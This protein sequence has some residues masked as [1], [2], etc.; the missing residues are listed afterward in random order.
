MANCANCGDPVIANNGNGYKSDK[1]PNEVFCSPECLNDYSSKKSV[2]FSNIKN[3]AGDIW[4]KENLKESAKF[5][6]GNLWRETLVGEVVSGAGKV[7]SGAGKVVS[8]VGDALKEDSIAIKQLIEKQKEKQEKLCNTSFGDD[9]IEIVDILNNLSLEIRST[10]KNESLIGEEDQ[11][12]L[13]NQY[14]QKYEQGLQR[15][16]LL[17]ADNNTAMISYEEAKAE[18]DKIQ[19]EITKEQAKQKKRERREWIVFG[20]LFVVGIVLF[21][22]LK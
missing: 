7:V 11:E 19:K 21:S 12:N 5:V 6:V 18:F 9:P 13:I 20:I 8:D 10:Y 4:E 17:S 22:L 15:L 1:F 2:L 16:Q 14:Y 3:V